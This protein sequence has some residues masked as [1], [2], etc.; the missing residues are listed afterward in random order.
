MWL[1]TYL[2]MA[3]RWNVPFEYAGAV[4]VIIVVAIVV[5]FSNRYWRATLRWRIE[6]GH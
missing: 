4:A 5:S 6:N 1:L 2:L 3:S